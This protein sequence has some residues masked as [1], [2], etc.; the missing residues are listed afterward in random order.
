MSGEGSAFPDH[1][2]EESE[3]AT[4]AAT[5]TGPGVAD[6]KERVEQVIQ[7]L[8]DDPVEC[9]QRDICQFFPRQFSVA[10]CRAEIVHNAV[11]D[12]AVK[13]RRVR[14]LSIDP[15]TMNRRVVIERYTLVPGP[16]NDE[17]LWA[18]VRAV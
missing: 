10:Q 17:Y 5:D 9:P 18:D 13:V 3:Q 14:C 12:V 1:P 8:V 6:L 15:A 4:S 16:L 7:E 2:A 11:R